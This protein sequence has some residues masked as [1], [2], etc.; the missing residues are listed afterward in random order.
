MTTLEIILLSYIILN[1][2]SFPLIGLTP[3]R[4]SKTLIFLL[5]I[6]NPIVSI[7]LLIT[8]M[9]GKFYKGKGVEKWTNQKWL[10]LW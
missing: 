5:I 8:D 10:T 9:I 7:F 3:K 4:H 2:I 6:L 1:W